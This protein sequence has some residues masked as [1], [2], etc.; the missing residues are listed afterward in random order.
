MATFLKIEEFKC[1]FDINKGENY[2]PKKKDENT[3]CKITQ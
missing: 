2:D 1:Q 3:K